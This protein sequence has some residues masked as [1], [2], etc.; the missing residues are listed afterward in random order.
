MTFLPS[1]FCPKTSIQHPMVPQPP[2]MPS[3]ISAHPEPF[4]CLESTWE[5]RSLRGPCSRGLAPFGCLERTWEGRSLQ[6]PCSKVRL[7]AEQV[8]TNEPARGTSPCGC[9]QPVLLRRASVPACP[10]VVL[11]FEAVAP[12]SSSEASATTRHGHNAK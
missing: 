4:R 1:L 12:G 11:P 8:A 10:A 2:P 3:A 9:A 6:G 7:T 5:G